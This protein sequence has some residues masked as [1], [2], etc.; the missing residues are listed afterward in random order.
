MIRFSDIHDA[1]L[2][3]SS[4]GYGMCTAVLCK[5]TEQIFY[6]SEM[7]DLDE[8]EEENLDLSKCIE[9][10]HKND[11]DLGNSLVFEFVEIH[12]P[13]EYNRVRQIFHKRGAYGRFKNLLESR[14]L[15][16]AWHEFSEQREE[17]ALRQWCIEN[18]IA[19]R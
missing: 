4:A 11:L 9:T 2:F 8:I 18:E 15:L 7:A 6:R 17:H 10:P 1:F 13:G 19:V 12:L 5:A 3:V 14:Q 16:K